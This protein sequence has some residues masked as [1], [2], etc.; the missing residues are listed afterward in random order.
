M[1]WPSWALYAVMLEGGPMG[2][3]RDISWEGFFNARDLG[4]L[5]TR[6]GRCTRR[7]ALIRLGDLR[8]VTS[9]GWQAS[10]DAGVRTILDLR[11]DDEI[12]RGDGRRLTEL[13]G[14]AQF[15]PRTAV[16]PFRPGWTGPRYPSTA[17]RT[18]S[19]GSTSTAS[20]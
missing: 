5:P 4:G 11:N 19:S 9:I 8:F 20:G 15:D 2:T 17:S 7:G 12:R 14:S 6:D 18:P 3:A 10:W 1:T 16:R 13:G